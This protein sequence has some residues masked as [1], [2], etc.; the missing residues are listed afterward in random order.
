[1]KL[2]YRVLC[3]YTL[4]ITSTQW[5]ILLLHR[6]DLPCRQGW[7]TWVFPV[8]TSQRY[9]RTGWWPTP[10]GLKH[11]VQSL[12]DD[13]TETHSSQSSQSQSS[14]NNKQKQRDRCE[15]L[16]NDKTELIFS[17]AD[18]KM[19]SSS[20]IYCRV[21]QIVLVLSPRFNHLAKPKSVSCIWPIQKRP[22]YNL[23]NLKILTSSTV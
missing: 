7:H 12:Q 22:G 4:E 1:M 15:S 18:Q 5:G 21:P 20:P 2:N 14:Q 23:W 11:R 19:A 10:Q 13:K 16:Q 8:T 6:R 9:G 17:Q 3:L